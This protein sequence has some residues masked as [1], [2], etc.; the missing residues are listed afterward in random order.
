[1]AKYQIEPQYRCYACDKPI[2]GPPIIYRSKVACS[3]TCEGDIDRLVEEERDAVSD[4]VET[5]VSNLPRRL[6]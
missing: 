4:T 6:R 3:I 2:I 1:M 5:W